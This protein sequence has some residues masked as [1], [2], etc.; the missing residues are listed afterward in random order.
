MPFPTRA[1]LSFL[2]IVV[3]LTCESLSGALRALRAGSSSAPSQA[4]RSTIAAR[5][6]A[7]FSPTPAVNTMPSTPPERHQR[8]EPV[9]ERVVDQHRGGVVRAAVHHPVAD[10]DRRGSQVLEQP[11]AEHLLR[12]PDVG[13][14]LRRGPAGGRPAPPRRPPPPPPARPAPCPPLAPAPAGPGPPPPRPPQRGT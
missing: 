2:P 1:F 7:A 10:R 5:T 8:L 12:P 3:L 13:G 11:A 6:G 4:Q 14:L 9:Q